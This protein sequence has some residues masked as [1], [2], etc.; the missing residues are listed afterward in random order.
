[1][2]YLVE[3]YDTWNR[4][5]HR[6]DEVPYLESVRRAPDQPDRISGV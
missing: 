6:F 5:V 3:I 2:E 1:M 4:R